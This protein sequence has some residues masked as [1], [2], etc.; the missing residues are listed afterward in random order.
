MKKIKKILIANR[1]EIAVRVIRACREMGI[2]TVAVYSDADRAALHVRRADEAYHLGANTPSESYLNVPKILD[3]ARKSGSDAIHPG[4]GF[5]SEN[6]DFAEQ[7]T[8]AGLIFIGPNPALIRAMG[9]KIEA[10]KI[11]QK[12]GVPIVP[13]IERPLLDVAEALGVAKEIG[14][15]VLLKAAAGGGG[16]GMRAVQKEEELKSAFEMAQSEAIKSFKDGAI[17]IEKY[18]EGPHHIEVQVFGDLHGSVIHFFE[19]ECSVQR[20]HQKVIEESPS[21]FISEKTRKAVCDMAVQ[22]CKSVNYYNAGTIEC[23][24]DKHQNY[25]F[26]EMNTRLQVE[27]PVTEMVTGVDLVKLQI[28]VAQGEAIPYRQEDLKQTGHAIECRVYAEDPFHNFM[29]SPGL[30]VD[31]QYPHGPGVRLDNGIYQGFQIPLEYDPV[32]SKLICWGR[33]RTE[34]IERTKR[35]LTEY[36]VSGPKTNLYFHRRAL[37]IDDFVQGNY[38][39]HF[40]AKH[41]EE[42]LKIDPT[43]QTYALMAA[44]LA[45][46]LEDE[47]RKPQITAGSVQDAS[48]WR[49]AGRAEGMRK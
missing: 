6:A 1:G 40:V 35:A 15:P 49:L 12:A 23:L 33:D 37:E 43:E 48:N 4:Y 7:I 3:A 31:Q 46:F 11:A 30:V 27:H 17:Y 5:L 18:V 19:R 8:K 28:L 34:A 45:K 2:Q 22:L 36:R 32:L 41:L 38:D 29:P 25:Y 42:I 24:V 20:R 9:S 14:Y 39:T 26:L 13:G 21:P 10:R 44:A 47:K 16:K